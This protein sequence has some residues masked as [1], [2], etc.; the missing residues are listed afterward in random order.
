MYC[1]DCLPKYRE[2]QATS[3]SDAGRKRMAE[4]RAVGRD[5]SR[6]G[7]AA[8]RR[9]AKH[10]Q[11]MMEQKTWESEHGSL[12]DPELFQ[13]EILP[14]LQDVSLGAMS[15]ATGL[16][17]QYCSV[18]RRGLKVPH[19]RHWEALRSGLLTRE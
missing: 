13:C 16:S 19:P 6:G 7:E 8:K 4:L 10:S 1:D 18:I 11:R 5:P 9:G 2:E 14:R 15:K 12:A 3:F 17:E